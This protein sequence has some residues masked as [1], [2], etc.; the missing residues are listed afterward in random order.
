MMGEVRW[1]T[2]FE[3]FSDEG[4]RRIAGIV[5][6]I[7]KYMDDESISVAAQFAFLHDGCMRYHKVAKTEGFKEAYDTEPRTNFLNELD[8]ITQMVWGYKWA[9][10][11]EFL[12]W[13]TEK[14]SEKLLDE[15]Y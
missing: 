15:I 6:D 8:K 1:R 2:D 14:A 7:V 10:F 4:N 12:F 5:K 13:K 9:D 11:A 3:M